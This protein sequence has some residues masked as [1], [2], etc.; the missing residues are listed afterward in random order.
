MFKK[1]KKDK[2]LKLEQYEEYNESSIEDYKESLTDDYD[3]LGDFTQDDTDTS[4]TQ[5][6]QDESTSIE[7]DYTD[8]NYYSDNEFDDYTDTSS[9]SKK[10]TTKKYKKIINIVFILAIIIMSLISIDVIC[11]GRYDIGPFF[12]IKT[13]TY[14]DGGTKVYYGLGYKVIKY[15]QLQGRRDKK[16]GFWTMPYSVEPTTISDIDLAIGLNDNTDKVYQKYYHEFLRI[17]TSV[18]K[19]DKVKNTL[20]V[21]YSDDGKKYTL[22]IVC[23][24]AEKNSNIEELEVGKKVTIIGT[25]KDFKLKDNSKPNQLSI[26]NCFAE[27]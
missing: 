13:T 10:T 9:H 23:T 19:I 3:Y 20:T 4:D 7:D 21:G 24:M 17:E 2:G 8:Y 15:H 18:K 5:D 6:T 22:D 14:K 25:V 11:V 27:Q 16:I 12:A 1:K 26:S